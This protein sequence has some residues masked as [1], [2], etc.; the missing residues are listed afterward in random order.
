MRRPWPTAARAIAG[1]AVFALAA[2][3]WWIVREVLI[4]LFY[5]G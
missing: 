5:S 1:L 3:S 2:A 4:A